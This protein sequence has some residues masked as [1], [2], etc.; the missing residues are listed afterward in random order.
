MTGD[1]QCFI[2]FIKKEG[3]LVSFRNNDKD[4]IKGKAIIG[5]KDSPKIEDVHSQIKGKAI[6][7]KKDSA[8]IEDVQYLKI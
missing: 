6:I 2:S 7:G 4:Q 1:K 3:G 8:K 5:K